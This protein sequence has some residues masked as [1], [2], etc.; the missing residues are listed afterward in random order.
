MHSLHCFSY[1][2]VC[3]PVGL[4]KDHWPD[5]HETWLKVEAWAKEERTPQDRS[6]SVT[7][8]FQFSPQL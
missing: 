6:L 3:L 1:G 2:P 7:F 5:F 4:Q 8:T